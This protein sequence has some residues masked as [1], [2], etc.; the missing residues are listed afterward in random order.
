MTNDVSVDV[1]TN[2]VLCG[3]AAALHDMASL[4]AKRGRYQAYGGE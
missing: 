2:G 3:R 1:E 4:R